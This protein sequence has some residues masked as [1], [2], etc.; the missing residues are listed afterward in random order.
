MILTSIE[1]GVKRIAE[2]D[3]KKGLGTLTS[4][5]VEEYLNALEC[6]RGD[7]QN[8]YRQIQKEFQPDL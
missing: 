6:L 4:E 5:D 1:A 8:L 7:V 3:T 2:L